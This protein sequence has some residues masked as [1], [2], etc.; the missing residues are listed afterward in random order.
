M[1]TRGT[2]W[3][4]NL[5]KEVSSQC[6]CA[7]NCTWVRQGNNDPREEPSSK[8][9]QSPKLPAGGKPPQTPSTHH[10]RQGCGHSTSL[11]K[12]C[13]APGPVCATGTHTQ[14][15]C[16]T[17]TWLSKHPPPPGISFPWT[18][19]RWGQLLQFC[20]FI[21]LCPRC[22]ITQKRVIRHNLQSPQLFWHP[23]VLAYRENW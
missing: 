23:T 22:A 18:G 20:C 21:L 5:F 11:P 9:T 10:C 4:Q 1:G 17:S 19:R 2:A 16:S 6:C 3:I 8:H 13:S 14:S 12:G 15:H 7:G